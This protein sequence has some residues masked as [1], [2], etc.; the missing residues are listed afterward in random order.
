MESIIN[1]ATDQMLDII[2]IVKKKQMWIVT[3]LHILGVRKFK[4]VLL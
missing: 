3:E 2:W 4:L 1:R